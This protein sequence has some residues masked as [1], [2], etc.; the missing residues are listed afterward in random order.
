MGCLCDVYE[1][2]TPWSPLASVKCNLF[3][4]C[5]AAVLQAVDI[6]A[7]KGSAMLHRSKVADIGEL[8][9]VGDKISTSSCMQRSMCF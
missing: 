8:F 2:I 7:C 6:S 9:S 4:M 5:L 1:N 3:V